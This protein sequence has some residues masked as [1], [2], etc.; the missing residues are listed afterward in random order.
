MALYTVRNG[1]HAHII[2]VEA[3]SSISKAI[4]ANLFVRP[5]GQV[6]QARTQFNFTS[7]DITQ[8]FELPIK[9]DEKSDFELRA[10]ATGGGGDI[11][12][13]IEMILMSNGK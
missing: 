6:F 2:K 10:K 1:Y 12:G 11:S 8:D 4:T 3:E 9:I 13:R 7:G 5:Q